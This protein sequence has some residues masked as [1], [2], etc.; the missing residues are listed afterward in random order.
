MRVAY[1]NQDPGVGP[2][3]HKGAA[4]HVAALQSALAEL[5]CEVLAL[6]RKDDAGVLAGLERAHAHRPIDFLYERHA[7]GAIGA[8]R[9][10]R[11]RG[12]P[13]LLEVNA[14][15][16]DEA[17]AH[18][19]FEASPDDYARQRMC[20]ESASWLLPVSRSVARYLVD[21]GASPGRIHVLPN[22]VDTRLFRPDVERATDFAAPADS[23]AIGFHGRL[24]PWHNLPL[25]GR[26]LE[27]VLDRGAR[28]RVLAVGE[29]D[30]ARALGPRVAEH[31]TQR[32]W[33]APQALARHVAC[34][35]V[36]PLSYA[37]AAE[38]YFSPL[39]L[40][41]AMA[42]GVTP[43]VPELG[44]LPQVVG[45]GSCGGVYPAGDERALAR[46]LL[47]WI[48]RPDERRRLGLEAA[49]AMARRSWVDVGR[50]VLGLAMSSC[51]LN[52]NLERGAQPR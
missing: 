5:G 14:P 31:L 7:L 1:V 22:A 13:L 27:L 51:G 19:G 34:F 4:A 24:R 3:R 29:G 2:G 18:R 39:K 35:D 41:E 48:E 12:V 46:R 42:C 11:A 15:L 6:E 50:E 30:F 49:R 17:R 25:L 52:R 20:L 44:E 9:F 33:M 40:F 37:P 36:L 26:A 10:A 8:A 38:L 47:Q 32:D 45:F 21:H 23:L 28:V 43:L 16:F